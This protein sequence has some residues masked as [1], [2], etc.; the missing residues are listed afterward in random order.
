TSQTP[1]DP[2]LAPLGDY[3]G[4]TPTHALLLGSPAVQAGDRTLQGALD[5]RG[6]VRG[7]V[8]VPAIGGFNAAPP[9]RFPVEAPEVVRPGAPVP[10]TLV[11]L[12]RWGN[13]ATTYTGTVRFSSTD[14]A[15]V[16]PP[17]YTFTG[18]DQGV[19]TFTF[20]LRTP[21]AQGVRAADL[22]LGLP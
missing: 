19:Q 13:R 8:F 9:E 21:G 17:Q 18:D 15:A 22:D 5:Q 20:T 4:P 11:A 7:G 2:R 14:F 12:D 3:G 1:L 6:S 16:L 10:V